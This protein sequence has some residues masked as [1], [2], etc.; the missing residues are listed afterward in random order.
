MG[1]HHT[2]ESGRGQDIEFYVCTEIKF[3]ASVISGNVP[4][5]FPFFEVFLY[6]VLHFI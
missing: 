6:F 4:L 2:S 5:F 3:N 1:I